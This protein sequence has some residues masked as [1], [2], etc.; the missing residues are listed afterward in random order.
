[1]D[2]TL[3]TIMLPMFQYLRKQ[4]NIVYVPDED[5]PEQLR[6]VSIEQKWHWILDEIIFA[7]KNKQHDTFWNHNNNLDEWLLH[8]KRCHNGLILIGKYFNSLGICEKHK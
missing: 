2:V 4:K 5:L 7:L 3:A 1:M 8:K 6:N